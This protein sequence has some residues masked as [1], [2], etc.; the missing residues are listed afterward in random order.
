M[1]VE[2][3][4]SLVP[5][6]VELS[7]DALILLVTNPVD[8]VT[9]AAMQASGLPRRRVFG[10]GTVLGSSRLRTLL[11]QHCEVAVHSV[12]PF[13]VGEHGDS[14]IPAWSQAS[15]GGVPVREWSVAGQ[16]PLDDAT[17]DHIADEV[18]TAAEQIIRGKGATNFAV[19]L[20]AA[21]IVEA[22]SCTTSAACSRSPRCS[23]ASWAVRRRF[24]LGEAGFELGS[25]GRAAGERCVGGG[26]ETR[27]V[28]S[29][30]PAR[31]SVPVAIVREW[32]GEHRSGDDDVDGGDIA[33]DG[34]VAT[35]AGKDVFE[36]VADLG[37]QPDGRLVEA[38]GATVQGEDEIVAGR[39]RLLEEALER[40]GGRPIAVGGGACV[41]KDEAV[42][43]LRQG[44]HEV[45]ACR[46]VAVQ[47]ADPDPGVVGDGGHRHLLAF[48]L[49]RDR[50]SCEHAIAVGCRVAS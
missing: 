3:C 49:D 21:G 31:K 6:I 35:S 48:V 50:G 2:M 17:L 16:P 42:G 41:V 45:R 43:A 7:P 15:I 14:Q 37:P 12:D 5:A 20:A 47:G 13:I 22:R 8:V 39:D 29:R 36:Q 38:D 27:D 19:G 24:C 18:V 40:V 25:G 33:A 1:N 46:V 30:L 23:P 9:Y 4:R 44:R 11:A 26:G 32:L 28:D 10:S 34:P